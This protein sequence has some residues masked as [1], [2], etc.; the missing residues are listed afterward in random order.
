MTV[1]SEEFTVVKSK[2]KNKKNVKID[3]EKRTTNLAETNE[4]LNIEETISRINSALQELKL[5]E[6]SAKL[7]EIDP[8]KQNG[9]EEIYC[10]GIGQM[11]TVISRY[12][13]ALLLFF[14]EK[15]CIP[16]ENS[17]IYD[18]IHCEAE[19]TLLSKIGFTVL[20]ENSQCDISFSKKSLVVLPHCPKELTNNLLYA[21]YKAK[22]TS[23]LVL[24]SNSISNVLLRTN[25]QEAKQLC[26]VMIL[27]DQYKLVNEYPIK[28]DFKYDDIFNDMS[29]HVFLDGNES[30]YEELK[31][32][33]YSRFD[34]ELL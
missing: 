16:Q 11:N 31:K 12:Q 25:P 23:N 29:V 1:E 32:P 27:A 34:S 22:T 30:F 33:D 14:Q 20:T 17:F 15:L 8:L 2:R 21:N 3:N 4:D 24:M 18:P 19:K 28:N 26:N 13:T 10:F 6:F 7:L 9:I 5:D